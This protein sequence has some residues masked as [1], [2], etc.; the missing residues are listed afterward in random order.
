LFGVPASDVGQDPFHLLDDQVLTSRELPFFF[1]P[2]FLAAGDV[3]KW[4]NWFQH[5]V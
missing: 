3:T 2:N 1:L 4:L 5:S